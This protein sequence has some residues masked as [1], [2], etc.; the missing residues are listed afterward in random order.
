MDVLES[1]KGNFMIA[2]SVCAVNTFPGRRKEN[3]RKENILLYY[4]WYTAKVRSTDG[5]T[6]SIG[7]TKGGYEANQSDWSEK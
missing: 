7:I 2:V 6:L 3:I 1:T 4:I 5:I